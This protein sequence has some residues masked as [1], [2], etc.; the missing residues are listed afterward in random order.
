MINTGRRV[1]VVARELGIN[2]AGLGRWVDLYKDLQVAGDMPLSESEQVALARL[3]KEVAELKLGRAFLNKASLFFVP[4]AS[5]TPA[6]QCVEVGVL[7]L[8]HARAPVDGEIFTA[9]RPANEKNNARGRRDKVTYYRLKADSA[10]RT[11]HAIDQQAATAEP[12]VPSLG[13]SPSSGAGSSPSPAAT[14]R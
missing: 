4:G 2:E 7:R 13:R 1:A 12:N 14:G 9:P 5:N 10:R 11:L 3:R 8:D 6:A